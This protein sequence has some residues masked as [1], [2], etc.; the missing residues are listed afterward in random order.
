MA[1]YR[2]DHIKPKTI[3]MIPVQ[4]YCN[5]TNFSRDSIRWLD[6]DA[7]T[8]G[9]R[10]LHSLNG[11]G[12]AKNYAYKLLDGSEVCKIRGF[13]L[14]FQNSLVLTYESVNELVSSM[15]ATRFNT[16]TNPRFYRTNVMAHSVEYSGLNHNT[17]FSGLVYIYFSQLLT[18]TSELQGMRSSGSVVVLAQ[19][20]ANRPSGIVVS[21]ADC[22]AIRSGF[23]AQ[24]TTPVALQPGR[25]NCTQHLKLG[26]E[27]RSSLSNHVTDNMNKFLLFRKNGLF[28]LV[29][30][31]QCAFKSSMPS[32][33]TL[34]DT[35]N[36]S[37]R[38][39]QSMS[40]PKLLNFMG[41]P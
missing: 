9:H 40:R 17:V 27:T 28:V 35:T 16:I 26:I 38:E 33:N 5:F 30:F 4:G 18:F 29:V 13:T 34:E 10:I 36:N 23:E 15:D 25:L 37:P 11:T 14:N 39:E 19:I 1:V 22:V 8:E 32:L 2:L 12:G 21:E 7:Q 24:I 3:A 41:R 31:P 20:V 6:F